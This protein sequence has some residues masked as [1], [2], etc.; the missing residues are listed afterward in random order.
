MALGDKIADLF[1]KADCFES[2]LYILLFKS[3]ETGVIFT[4]TCL[5]FQMACSNK[6]AN[7]ECLFAHIHTAIPGDSRKFC[8]TFRLKSITIWSMILTFHLTF[9]DWAVLPLLFYGILAVLCR[10]NLMGVRPTVRKIVPFSMLPHCLLARSN[11][12][13]RTIHKSRTVHQASSVLSLAIFYYLLFKKKNECVN[14]LSSIGWN[15]KQKSIDSMVRAN[16]EHIY[17]YLSVQ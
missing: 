2:P 17:I 14:W 12:D 7:I 4:F 5:H 10:L 6:N 13:L 8:I 3:R 16:H 1:S 9:F 15:R 11:H